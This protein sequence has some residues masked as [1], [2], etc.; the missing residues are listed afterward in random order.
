MKQ[1]RHRAHVFVSADAGGHG[2]ILQALQY[3]Q[4]RT[5]VRRLSSFFELAPRAA[6]K[7]GRIG[8]ACEVD[9][10]DSVDVLSSFL[11][12][13]ERRM[14]VPRALPV[15]AELLAYDGRLL[16]DMSPHAA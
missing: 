8:V 2:V 12:W 9:A 16:G 10:D 5:S 1:E 3:L 6:K 11:R 14:E 15:S 4:A 13:V 7:K